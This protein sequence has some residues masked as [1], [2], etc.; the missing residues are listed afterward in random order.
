[1]KKTTI[2]IL[3]FFLVGTVQAITLKEATR[4]AALQFKSSSKILSGSQ[5][6]ISEIISYHS[7]QKDILSRKIEAELYYG[8]EKEFQQVKLIDKSEA[9]SGFS[10]QTIIIKGEYKQEGSIVNLQLKAVKGDMTGAIIDQVSVDFDTESRERSLVVVL[11]I[12]A[13]TLNPEQRKVFS[14][15][16][17]FGFQ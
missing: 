11:D 2:C 9:L 6:V 15:F 17:S 4:Q 8:F 13:E 1:M 3:M 14:N 10:S 5:I 16:S 12:E 7:K